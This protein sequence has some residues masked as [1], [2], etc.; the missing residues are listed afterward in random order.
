[1]G[2]FRFRRSFKIAPGV[3]L[4]LGKR[5]LS[6]SFGA[7]GIH[8]TI[9][10]AGRRFTVGAPGTGLSYTTGTRRSG[11]SIMG[12]IVFLAAVAFIVWLLFA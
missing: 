1:M 7:K 9:G 11:G 8:E 6:T 10:T 3:R 2:Y 5:S 4:N 12:A